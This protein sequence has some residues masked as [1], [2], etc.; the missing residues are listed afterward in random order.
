MTPL[1]QISADLGWRESELASL[2]ILLVRHDLSKTQHAVLLRAS[3]AML[4]AHYEGFVKT[5][6]TI[7]YDEVCK[8]I[9]NCGNLP[10]ETR[11]NALLSV[12]KKIR[13]LP[14]VEMLEEIEE[15]CNRHHG[16]SPQFPEVDTK[17]NLWPNLLADLL[18][19]ADIQP[20][21]AAKHKFEIQ[22]LV[23]RRNEIAHGR[24]DLISEIGY[25][26]KYESVVYDIMY[27]V[28]FLVD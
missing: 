12:I 24:H 21:I 26:V 18:R 7:F 16:S 13:Q 23:A 28:A 15:F 20:D 10:K 2:K 14:A 19:G 25:Y 17:S 27:E 11:V 3:W 8:R 6:L 22:T 1:E 4:Y 5:A 9:G